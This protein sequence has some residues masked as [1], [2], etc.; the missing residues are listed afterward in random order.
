MTAAAI[1]EE[2]RFI[3]ELLASEFVF[4]LPF[5]QRKKHFVPVAVSGWLVFSLL[6]QG[7]FL[8]FQLEGYVPDTVFRT[9]IGCWYIVLALLAMAFTC[10]CFHL[11]FSDALYI[12]IAG[13]SA[14]HIVYILI[15]EWLALYLWPELSDHLFVYVA[16]SLIACASLLGLLHRIFARSLS[17]CGGQLFQDTPANILFHVVL[18]VILMSCTFSCQHLFQSVEG[19]KTFGV[20]LGLTVCLLILGLQYRTLNAIQIR[21]E[22]AVIEQML[23]SSGRQYQ[24][25]KELVDHIQRTCHDLKHNLQVLKTIDSAQRQTYIEETEQNIALYHDLIHT[26]N[27]VLNTIL[28]EKCLYCRNHNIR[29]SCAVDTG[30]MDFI[31]IPDL[32]AILGNAIDNAIECVNRFDDP[33]KRVISLAITCHNAF[34]CIQTNNFSNGQPTMMDGLPV[35]TKADPNSHGFGLKSIRY[36]AEKYG[37]SVAVSQENHV[38][39]LQIMFPLPG[40]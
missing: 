28:G 19:A 40:E 6:S 32:Y 2:L 27:E 38:F 14:Q 5:A 7:Y 21:Q 35:T 20:Q 26:D 31:S 30:N 25:S 16:I 34:I 33:E 37:G 8:I 18:L 4:L 10:C 12:C 24:L 23:R 13:Y 15:H 22:R 11:T 39:T 1:F 36:L 9:T 3:W 17:Q 29:L